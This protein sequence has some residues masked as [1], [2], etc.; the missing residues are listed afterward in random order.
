MPGTVK[1]GR[2]AGTAGF[3]VK[4]NNLFNTASSWNGSLT[5]RGASFT[6]NIGGGDLSLKDINGTITLKDEGKSENELAALVGS[7][8]D[9]TKDV[10]KNYLRSFKETLKDSEADHLRI[11][12]IEYGILRFENVECDLVAGRDRVAITKLVSGF[13]GGKLFGRGFMNLGGDN[14]DY[15]LSFLFNDISLDAISKR[16]SPSEEYIT[17]RVNGLVWLSGEGG[18]L[19]TIDGPFEFWSVSSAKERR[20]IGKALLDKLGAKERLI[21]GSSRSY[22]NGEISG[23]IKDGVI[24][25]KKFNISNSILGIKNLSIQADPVKNSISISHLVSVIREIARRSQT[26][27]PS[28]QTQ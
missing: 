1:E 7:E 4:V 10:Y 11:A 23:Y 6:A 5:L 16:L 28:I 22:D 25:F 14:S 15:N 27:G 12:E 13:F 17:G 9:L 20:E 18:E 2:V 26:G 21:L 3:V 8:L 19:G 24:T